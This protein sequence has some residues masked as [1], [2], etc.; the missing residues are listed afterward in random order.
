MDDDCKSW[1]GG[2]HKAHAAAIMALSQSHSGVR[3]LLPPPLLC[4]CCCWLSSEPSLPPSSASF[5][6]SSPLHAKRNSRGLDRRWPVILHTAWGQ[7][8]HCLEQRDVSRSWGEA[9]WG[10]M[11]GLCSF[12]RLLS[13]LLWGSGCFLTQYPL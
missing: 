2:K 11:P 7:C 12:P 8:S 5:I 13:S 6:P 3:T 9:G 1:V 4:P 10:I